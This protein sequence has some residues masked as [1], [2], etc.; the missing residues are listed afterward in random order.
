M[1][2]NMLGF[3]MLAVFQPGLKPQLHNFVVLSEAGYFAILREAVYFAILREAVYFAILRD[4]PYVVILR[5]G[6]GSRE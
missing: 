2:R 3:D 5:E 1:G 4:F 6:G